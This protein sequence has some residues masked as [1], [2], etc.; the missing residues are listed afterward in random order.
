MKKLHRNINIGFRVTE[1]EQGLMRQRME[2]VGIRNLRAYLL[3]M[4]LNGYIIHIDL[5]DVRECSRL[6]RI[7]GN[8]VNQIAARVNA[9]GSL[10]AADLADMRER[11][12]GIWANQNK[13][14]RDLSNILEAA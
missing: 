11:L 13:I 4:A 5:K 9:G 7:V 1:E 12:D 14:I 3:K 2:E 6:L 10:Y 8:N